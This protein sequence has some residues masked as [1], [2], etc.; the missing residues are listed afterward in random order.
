[1][2]APLRQAEPNDCERRAL[3]RALMTLSSDAGC[4][5]NLGERIKACGRAREL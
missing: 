2:T 4:L 1:M 5:P 3:D